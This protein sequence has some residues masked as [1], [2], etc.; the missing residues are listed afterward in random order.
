MNQMFHFLFDL[1]NAKHF[2]K[3]LGVVGAFKIL[4]GVHWGT[5]PTTKESSLDKNKWQ[6]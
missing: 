6:T 3:K 2:L 4:W 5:E 1:R